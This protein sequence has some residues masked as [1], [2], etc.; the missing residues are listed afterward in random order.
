M[1]KK[2]V[3]DHDFALQAVPQANRRGFWQMFVVM[4]G[5]TF[6]SASMWSGGTLGTGLT[7]NQFILVVLAGNLVLGLYTGLLSYI[8]SQTGLSTHLLARY[9]FGEKGSYLVSFMLGAT[10]VGWFGVG[11]AMF[12]LPVQ[13]VT[14]INEYLLIA[15]AGLLMT[16]TAYFGFKALTIL[17][18]IAVPS[19]AILG[20]FSVLKATE[21][22]GGLSGLMQYQPVE[23]LALAT[24][25]TICIGSFISGGTLT[26]DFARFARSKRIAVSTTV[27]AFFIGNSL[28]F[29]FGAIGAMSL[30]EADVSEVMFLQGLIIPAIII[31]GLNIWTTNDNALYA[32]G[33]G[34]SNITKLPKHKLVLFNGVIGTI[35]ALWLYNNFVGWLT[36]LGST[37]PPV[38]A[39]IL[40]DY[41]ILKR[42]QYALLE[43]AS[44]RPLHW[45]AILAWGIGI[46]AAHTLPGI[47]PLN[48]IVASALSY[49]ILSIVMNKV[50]LPLPNKAKKVS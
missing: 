45:T 30:G 22:S 43:Q 50:D 19:I 23:T 35:L 2:A 21:S 31:L 39:I 20:S 13:K 17:S 18:F 16:I 12:A 36:F 38:G 4:M 24:A 44:L 29:I 7:F 6:F 48:A 27:M 10:Q 46:V 15:I 41:F 32:S 34:F 9:A 5:F 8:A 37:L 14:G 28:M 26:P 49:L 47:P 42:K 25:L 33:L 11:V 1:I 40:A 3:H